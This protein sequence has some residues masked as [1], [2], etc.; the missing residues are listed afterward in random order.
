MSRPISLLRIAAAFALA[1]GSKAAHAES[2][3]AH[4]AAAPKRPKATDPV[5]RAGSSVR[6]FDVLAS[7][8]WGSST[9]NTLQLELAP[10]G[11]SFGVGVG[12]TWSAGFRLGGYLARSLGHTVLQHREPFIGPASEFSAAT[13]SLNGGLSVGW[14]VPLYAFVLRY[15]LGFGVTAMRWEFQGVSAKSVNFGDGSSPS[16]GV[17]VAPGVALLWPCGWFEGG[18]GFEYLAQVNDVIPSGFV[19]QLLIGVK[20]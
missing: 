6:G 20:L 15:T 4:N 11:A 12:Y 3:A 18:V 9:G 19:G 16:L 10:Y 1:V 17:H 13:S 2:A 14:D 7:V 5:A 8:G